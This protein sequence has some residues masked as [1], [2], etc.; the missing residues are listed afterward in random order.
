MIRQTR[1]WGYSCPWMCFLAIFEEVQH[2]NQLA[3]LLEAS[4]QHLKPNMNHHGQIIIGHLAK[5]LTSSGSIRVQDLSD[6]IKNMNAEFNRVG[7]SLP[8]EWQSTI[9]LHSLGPDFSNFKSAYLPGKTVK[10]VPGDT[11][12]QME[13]SELSMAAWET[14]QQLDQTRG[15]SFVS[16]ATIQSTALVASLALCAEVSG[17][18][19]TSKNIKIHSIGTKSATV[20]IPFCTN[21]SAPWRTTDNCF[22]LHSELRPLQ[23]PT[24]VVAA[25]RI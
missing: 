11:W 5:L 20:E 4:K 10:R 21:C 14:E 7:M 25:R 24:S 15:T 3:P 2:E 17:I 8:E 19:E 13:F 1:L 9:F 23:D 22:K 16:Q 12:S 18:E 6:E